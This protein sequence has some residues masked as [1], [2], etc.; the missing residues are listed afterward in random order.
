MVNPIKGAHVTYSITG[1]DDDGAFEGSR[2]Y[3]D[4]FNVRNALLV[5]WPGIYIPSIPPKKSV[6][7][8]EDNFV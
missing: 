5:R 1:T 6:G 3:N 8:K 2:R 7:N 4:F